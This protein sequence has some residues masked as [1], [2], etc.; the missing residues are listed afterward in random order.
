M[1]IKIVLVDDHK[2][3]REGIRAMLDTEK[4]LEVVSEA[5]NGREALEIALDIT[6]Y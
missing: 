5:E 1:T 2:I 6:R 3:M 4:G